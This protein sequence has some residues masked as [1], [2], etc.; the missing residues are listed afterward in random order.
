MTDTQRIEKLENDLAKAASWM[1]LVNMNMTAFGTLVMELK[2][3]LKAH[4]K[5]ILELETK[6]AAY[7]KSAND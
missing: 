7:R 2:A 6:M 5:L 3:E 4:Q 1:S